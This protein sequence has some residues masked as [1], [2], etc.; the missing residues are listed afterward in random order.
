DANFKQK[1][2]LHPDNQKDPPL[3]PG[4]GTFIENEPYLRYVSQFADRD[5]ISHC[6]GFQALSG[7]NN[8]QSKGLWATGIGSVSCACQ[9]MYQPNGM[10]DLQK[11]EQYAILSP[12]IFSS[13]DIACQWAT[14][15]FSRMN[16]P[17]MPEWLCLAPSTVVK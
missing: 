4:W 6:A 5:K 9:E 17:T 13:L 15:F 14:N 10:G 3:G 7:A 12:D 2:Q 11:G 1:A 16:A 8:K